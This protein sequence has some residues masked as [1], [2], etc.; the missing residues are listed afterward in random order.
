MLELGEVGIIKVLCVPDVLQ[1]ELGR[2][3]RHHINLSLRLAE[4]SRPINCLLRVVVELP[5]IIQCEP[6]VSGDGRCHVHLLHNGLCGL[7]EVAYTRE[8]VGKVGLDYEH[9]HEELD[10]EHLASL[11]HAPG[12]LPRPSAVG[13]THPRLG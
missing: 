5:L 9:P 8:L 13:I 3:L 12:T 10:I 1:V 11:G 7:G 2:Q 6:H 4:G